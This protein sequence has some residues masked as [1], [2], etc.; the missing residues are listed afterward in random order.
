V[1]KFKKLR[2]NYEHLKKKLRF[3]EKI[4]L[5]LNFYFI[6]TIFKG[7]LKISNSKIGL[8]DLIGHF[9]DFTV[10]CKTAYLWKS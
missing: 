2:A 1:V 7:K 6:F 4:G 9:R 8:S 5:T 3:N 10:I